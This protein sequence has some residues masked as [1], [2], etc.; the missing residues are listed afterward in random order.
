LVIGQIASTLIY[1]A[2]SILVARFLGSTTYGEM[3][4]AMIPISIANLFGNPGIKGGL[5]RYI[6][7]FRTEDRPGDVRTL[8]RAGLLINSAAGLVLFLIIFLSSGFLADRVFHQP[9]V[10]PL[11]QIASANL[12]A[13][14][15][16]AVA[17]GV[18][19]GFERMEFVSSIV[20][21][22]S[23]IKSILAPLLVFLGLGALG[24]VLGNTVT[25]YIAGILGATLV[26]F[27]FLR[28]LSSDQPTISYR[29]GVE[30]LLTYGYPLFLSTLIA[31][32]LTQVYRFLMALYVDTF[33]IGNY[34][35]ATHFSVLITF[36][37]MPIATV[38]FPLF[39][40]LDYREDDSLAP[41]FQNAVKYTSLI[42][43]PVTV[44]LTLLSEPMVRIIY[45]NGFPQTA[46][47]LKL[48]LF[49]FLF[50][51]MGGICL[52]S[53]L[54]GQG[55]TN[56]TFRINVLNLC[57]GLPLSLILI[58][59]FGI[60]GLLLTMI[61]APRAG[62]LYSLWWVRRN[63]GFSV[64][65]RASAKIY[66]SSAIPYV[67]I[68]F[69]LDYLRWGDWQELFLGGGLFVVLYLFLI[70]VFRTLDVG[71]IRDLRPIL[72]HMGPLTPV[73]NV[74]LSI[75]EKVLKE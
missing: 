69:F 17:R 10:Q 7:Q 68:Y 71:D 41:V 53:L 50:V 12:L 34:Q 4:I 62:H 56:V 26:F 13:H 33:Y 29:K 20:I 15:V 66:L 70:F 37:T 11:M 59:R 49:P 22:Q 38:L 43:V 55:K 24:A 75:F 54:N 57:V 35:A 51:G 30:L 73:F 31:G 42:T 27:A 72:G 3:T 52:G 46:F 6:S 63:F 48:F 1:A 23:I 14:S 45:G 47:F 32:T 58:P 60:V 67:A 36:L 25:L 74:I 2:G 40:K 28:P 39:S 61:V 64:D 21:V 9:E 5:I 44:V 19:I 8:I 16:I 65:W 18:F